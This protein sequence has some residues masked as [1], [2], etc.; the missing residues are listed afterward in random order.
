MT[1]III[2]III[3]I[4]M[5]TSIIIIIIFINIMTI[6]IMKIEYDVAPRG[7]PQAEGR[8]LSN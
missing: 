7:G 2:I 5:T 3:I 6:L 8:A 4:I 1:I